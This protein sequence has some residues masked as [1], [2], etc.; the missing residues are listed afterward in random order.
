MV[1]VMA[2]SSIEA[3]ASIGPTRAC[4]CA[5]TQL[6][7]ARRNGG[8]HR[9]RQG[10]VLITDGCRP[11]ERSCD[12]VRLLERLERAMTLYPVGR[13]NRQD[14]LLTR[15]IPSMIANKLISWLFEYRF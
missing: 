15:K 13:Q 3:V 5:Q 9:R 2:V 6:G 10:K 11:A 14:K 7:Q 1:P 8:R 4:S 12:I